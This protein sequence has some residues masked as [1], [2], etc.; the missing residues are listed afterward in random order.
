MA[1]KF[2]VNGQE[3]LLYNNILEAYNGNEELAIAR[4]SY[5]KTDSEFLKNF[6]DW[7]ED[8]NREP[9]MKTVDYSYKPG[10]SRIEDNG[11]PKLFKNEK[12][13]NYYYID[14]DKNKVEIIENT[15]SLKSLFNN[16]QIE[17]ITKVLVN[18]YFK[19]HLNIDF[20]NINLNTEFV[21]IRESII[22]KLNERIDIFRD[23]GN[24]NFEDIA[25]LLEIA[26]DENL[27]ELVK[28]VVNS[29]ETYKIKSSENFNKDNEDS[30]LANIEINE[31]EKD[32]GFGRASYE[33][34][35]KGNISANVKL[36]LSLIVNTL[37][38]DNFLNDTVYLSFDEVYSSLLPYLT[39]QVAI[40]KDGVQEDK[41]EIMKSIILEISHKKPYF[42]ELYRLLS[43]P[44][45]S[46]EI[47]NEF[48]QAFNLDLNNFNTS[49]Y[50]YEESTNE[51]DWITVVDQN[52]IERIIKPLIKTF[53][54]INVSETGKK[55]T[56][57]FN[58]W[59]KNFKSRFVTET[60]EGSTITK[61]S[62]DKLKVIQLNLNKIKYNQEDN[63]QRIVDILRDIGVENTIKGFQHFIDDLKLINNDNELS[64]KIFNKAVTDLSFF[65]KNIIENKNTNYNNILSDQNLFKQLAKAESFYISEGSDASVFTGG[66]QKWVYSYPSYLSNTIKSWKKDRNI[67]LKHYEVS[68]FNEGSDWMKYLLALDD[69]YQVND[70]LPQPVQ[71]QERIK[72]SQRRIN[73]LDIYTFNTSQEEGNSI[74]GKTNKDISKAEYISDTINKLL[75][76]TVNRKTYYRTTTPADKGTQLEISINRYLTSNARYGNGNRDIVVNEEVINTIFNYFDAEYKRMK[77]EREFMNDPKNANKL[78]V[79]YHLGAGHAFKSQLFPSLSFD[80]ITDTLKNSNLDFKNIYD[81]NGN[82]YLSTLKNSKFESDIKSYI[83]NELSNGIQETLDNLI[84]NKIFEETSEG[85]VNKELDN[86]IWSFYGSNNAL[87]ASADFFINSLMSHVEYSKMFAGDVAYYK[88]A[89]DYKKRVPATYTDGLYQRLNN[90][91]KNYTI[92]SIESVE[93]DSPFLPE[94][95]ELLGETLGNKYKDINSADAQAWISPNRWKDLMQTIGKWNATYESAYNK[96]IGDNNEPFTLNELKAVAPPLKGVYFQVVDGVPIFLKY[97]QAVLSPRLRKGNG[98]EILYDKMVNNKDSNGNDFPI[99]ELVTF[100]AIKVGSN[101]P[102]KVHDNNGQILDNFQLQGFTIPSNGWKLQQDLP[103]K[104]MHDTEVGSQIQKNIFQGLAFNL[105]KDFTLDIPTKTTITISEEQSEAINNVW[106]EN[107]EL[108]EIF[109]NNKGLYQEYL[110]SIFPDSQIKDIVYRGG[111]ITKEEFEDSE[112]T[113]TDY[114]DLGSGLY[115]SPNKN[116]AEQYGGA[117]ATVIN[118]K[119]PKDVKIAQN[120]RAEYGK[121]DGEYGIPRLNDNGKFDGIVDLSQEFNKTYEVVVFNSEQIHILGSKQDIQQAK[122]FVNKQ[123]QSGEVTGNQMV[124]NIANVIGELSNLGYESV[125]K[126]F[127]VDSNGVITNI[128]GFYSSIVSELKSR[129][130]SQNIIDALESEIS[131]YGVAQAKDK[132]QNIFSSILTKRMLKIKTNGGSFIQM[133]NFGL[134]S[135][136]P[137][138]QSIIW[139][140]RA[141]KTTHE[142]QFLRD[143][144]GEFILSENGKKII[145]PGGILISGSFIAKYIPDYHKYK[146]EQLFGY[147]NENGEFVNGIIDRKILENIVGYR[148]P[149]QGLS[150]NDA[151]EIV[152]I[153]PEETGD[154]VV[155]YTGITTKTGSDYDIDK[156]YLMFPS[157]KGLRK[158]RQKLR[159]YAF[160]NLRGKTL[161]NTIDNIT[162]VIDQLDPEDKLVNFDEERFAKLLL[163]TDN[164]ELLNFELDNFV[165]AVL[166][167]KSELAKF[168]KEEIPNYNNVEKLKYINY[169]T[170]KP[171]SEQTKEALQNRLIELYKSVLLNE[172]VIGEVMTPVD[173]THIKDDILHFT[174]KNPTTNLSTFNQLDD[175]DTKYD[176]SAGKA[177]VG[178]QANALMDYVL[179]SLGNLSITN[180]N[181]PKSNN[182][183]DLEYSNTLSDED[184]KYYLPIAKKTYENTD[185]WKKDK[186]PFNE[187]EATKQ[188]KS[189][190]IGHSLSA[191]LN[192]FVDIAK[193]PYITRG[194]WVTMTTNTGNL[195]LRKGVHPFYV[196]AFLNQPILKEYVEFSASYE[197]SANQGLSTQDAFIK[198]RFSK[199]KYENRDNSNIFTENLQTLRSSQFLNSESSQMNVFATFL[200][201][202]SASKAIKDNIN[203]SKFMVD[204]IG[205]SVN[206]LIIAKNAVDS[207]LEAENKY[208]NLSEKDKSEFKENIILGFRSKF[209]NPNGSES[210]F[211]KYYK[212]VILKPI[213]IVKS[214]PI[215]FLEGNE[216]IQNTFNEISY[217]LKNQI[218]VDFE[219]G[220]ANLGKILNK[221]FYS[222]IMSG[223]QPLKTTSKERGDLILN[224]P[225][226]FETFKNNNSYIITEQITVKPGDSFEFVGLN[227]RKKSKEFEESMINSF[228][229]LLN[230]NEEFAN[231]LIKYSYLTSGFNNH[232]SQFFTMIPTQWFNR[233]NINR[234]I[235]DTDNKYKNYNE[236]NDVN[237]IDHFYLSNLDNRKFVK[238]IT[239]DQIQKELKTING[240][241]VK[242]PGKVGYYR[243]KKSDDNPDIYYKLIGYNSNYQGVYTRFILNINSEFSEIKPLNVRDKKGNR[244][245]N[246]DTNG[247]NLKAITKTNPEV[248]KSVDKNQIELLNN[249][250]IISRDIFYRENIIIKKDN[251]VNESKPEVKPEQII[252]EF[253]P[254]KIDSLPPN[255]IFVFGSNT[256]GK[257]GKGAAL[258]AKTKF[259][260][261]QGQSSGIQ[262]QSYAIITKDLKVGERSVT[263]NSIGEQL[264]NLFEYASNN[265]N[266]KFYVTKLGSSLAGFTVEEIRNEINEV[267]L[268]NGG[269]FIPNNVILPKEYEVRNNQKSQLDLF[270]AT[271][272]VV[273]TVRDMLKE[274][275]FDNF[276][277]E[278]IKYSDEFFKQI[279]DNNIK[280]QLLNPKNKFTLLSKEQYGKDLDNVLGETIT[281]DNIEEAFNNPER[282]LEN[283]SETEFLTNYYVEEGNN[284][285]DYSQMSIKDIYEDYIKAKSIEEK[286]ALRLFLNTKDFNLLSEE[287]ILKNYKNPNQLSLF[288]ELSEQELNNLT[289]EEKATIQWQKKNCK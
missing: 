47:K 231:K 55:E 46:E 153:L 264:A 1:C 289:E 155:A 38:K 21:S 127:G 211:S 88:N 242:K 136:S 106:N 133:S 230:D 266:K 188:L 228:L 63:I 177:G 95:T 262:G 288:P 273:M 131:I 82:A 233:N 171:D 204:G 12:N 267:N 278:V 151:L 263:L 154:T 198:E 214:N 34:S 32:P 159:D 23:S 69:T 117:R 218:L 115:L 112:H 192:A 126:E 244:I 226:E 105:D 22:D 250:A 229:D 268:V 141:L 39:N 193:D 173:F 108:K 208:N 87:K 24:D 100:D 281:K 75:G 29:L 71:E 257:H 48:T 232:S 247:I 113:P 251:N 178:Q 58:E 246:F 61:E 235:I 68:K 97:S 7:V 172:N 181:V 138:T 258:T 28:N 237:F 36:R 124:E 129:G 144:K 40:V 19:N 225:K 13:G 130:G 286:E 167:S 209:T 11:E 195:L 101:R 269:N 17:S 5:F 184:I 168:I 206:S 140:P 207:I 212:N 149:N 180:F 223:F 104:T 114:M 137:K 65:V 202:Q 221:T 120:E 41:F 147:T 166:K 145:R 234:Y 165:E 54:N 62:K 213:D 191:I 255:G 2:V 123:P 3:S 142:P 265:P 224:F 241:V 282:V 78:R 44:T 239:D 45:L 91:N 52:N 111:N 243:V 90:D 182:R 30:D 201:Y 189:I 179:G 170:T 67:L 183:F 285:Y 89:V 110:N 20:E 245:V 86:K 174:D 84:K 16:K 163:A 161:Q 74:D 271:A 203:A 107:P 135:D 118:I 83:A 157:F 15:T 220:N 72:E 190:K 248:A 134:Y 156:M 14:K 261:K 196:N 227:N 10:I 176:F 59:N 222:Y 99:D 287:D 18:N 253:T 51:A 216:T 217:D 277:S 53:K 109:K 116:I 119:T 272:E 254:D 219:K 143:E 148:I 283:G 249:E 64:E 256:E 175:I 236:D 279:D 98:L 139:S 125:L 4:H 37:A 31:N 66:K 252:Q 240:F 284:G 94:I 215:L 85:I 73:D 25:D 96:L 6:G 205:G 42:K 259:G 77:F 43:Q 200:K 93:I 197:S 274:E 199:K 169:D 210:M 150:S 33:M 121:K 162:K 238:N 146:P 164:K 187:K 49:E 270:G 57:V 152:G 103:I 102:T 185:A 70:F 275:G 35:T 79:Y 194:N 50:S 80:K 276:K 128:E 76:F 132:L 8:F 56:D 158:E 160:K 81:E 122:D 92:A 60:K 9:S 26:L 27:D 186:I 280:E 260:A